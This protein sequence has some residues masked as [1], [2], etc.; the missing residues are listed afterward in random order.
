FRAL[1]RLGAV[2]CLADD[3]QVVLR[4]QEEA[5]A[6]PHELLVVDDQEPDL[7]ASLPE[8]SRAATRKPPP[9][10]GPVS[11]S[12]PSR[13]TRSRMPMRPCPGTTASCPC[14]EPSSTIS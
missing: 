11:S 3:L 4:L 6:G 2:A 7:H 12:P 9:S 10:R 14:G 8:G 1:D 5:E 13:A